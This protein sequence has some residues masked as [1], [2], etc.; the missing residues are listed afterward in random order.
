MLH[1]TWFERGYREFVHAK[2]AKKRVTPHARDQFFFAGDDARLRA[3]Q[4]FVPA[5][6]D[7][8]NARIDA[9]PHDGF[10]DSAF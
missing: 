10:A 3:A 8:R 5:E 4:K 1:G 6:G 7:D 9:L 2:R